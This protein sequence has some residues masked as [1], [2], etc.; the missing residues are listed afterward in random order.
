MTVFVA[1]PLIS[2]YLEFKRIAAI[3]KRSQMFGGLQKG[4]EM[5]R[6]WNDPSEMVQSP[7]KP[8]DK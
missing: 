2:V 5:H 7:Q 3:R 4:M 8:S 1:L 6:S